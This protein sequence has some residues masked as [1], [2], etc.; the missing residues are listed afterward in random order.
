MHWPHQEVQRYSP[1][2]IAAWE[3]LLQLS[4][5]RLQLGVLPTAEGLGAGRDQL[6]GLLQ[7]LVI[8]LVV[9]RPVQQLPAQPEM[10]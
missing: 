5:Q 9:G 10:C 2:S 8:L 4:I 3:M 6:Q 7:T 1:D